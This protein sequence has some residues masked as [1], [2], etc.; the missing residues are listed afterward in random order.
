[1]PNMEIFPKTVARFL[2]TA[3]LYL[4]PF[5]G[6]QCAMRD[7]EALKARKKELDLTNQEIADLSGVPL[8][9]VQ[10]VFSGATRSPGSRTL[11]AIERA[12]FPKE[13]EDYPAGDP[14]TQLVKESAIV[15]GTK[16]KWEEAGFTYADYAALPMPRRWQ[17]A[18][19]PSSST[20]SMPSPTKKKPTPFL[21]FRWFS[22]PSAWFS[23]IL[24]LL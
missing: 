18:L 14:G 13:A 3:L 20:E 9:T 6:R 15:Y 1:M 7:V 11:L 17:W 16:K 10:K 5:E 23:P 4:Y 8:G 21:S 24:S 12:L 22:G 19:S 2:S